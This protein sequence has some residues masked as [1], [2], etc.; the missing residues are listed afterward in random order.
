ME[1]V[2]SQFLA[3]G[4]ESLGDFVGVVDGD[5]VDAAGVEVDGFAELG[6]DDGGTFEVPARVAGSI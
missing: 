3:E 6:V 2:V 4:A 1:P 5:V